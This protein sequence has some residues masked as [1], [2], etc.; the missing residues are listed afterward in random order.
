MMID[1]FGFEVYESGNYRNCQ[2]LMILYATR[3]S[4]KAHLELSVD[5]LEREYIT[6][7]TFLSVPFFQI[8]YL[9]NDPYSS[10]V[11]LQCP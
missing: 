6:Y 4:S 2:L 8:T 11:P 7:M 1:A 9:R 3:V 5:K 10:S